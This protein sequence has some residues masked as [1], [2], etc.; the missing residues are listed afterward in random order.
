MNFKLDTP[1]L[2]AF[3]ELDKLTEA[4][5][6]INR[7]A[8]NPWYSGAFRGLNDISTKQ[9]PKSAEEIAQEEEERRKQEKE[10]HI[11]NAMLYKKPDVYNARYQQTI[12][13]DPE[14]PALD[15]ETK[16]RI[17]DPVRKEEVVKQSV[18]RRELAQQQA[19]QK[20]LETK[21]A[22][23]LKKEQTYYWQAT[24]T[25]NNRT[26]KIGKN[27]VGNDDPD[28]ACE[29]IK[30]AALRRIKEEKHECTVFNEPF[31]W[32]NTL[33]ISCTPPKGS[34]KVVAEISVSEEELD[35]IKRKI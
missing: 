7:V 4:N 22:N 18:E 12:L 10:Q 14:W 5:K 34:S 25:L 35:K 19:Y 23:K 11:R 24:Y 32:D 13:T 33:T 8:N 3:E 17:Y 15:P 2:E 20:G 6:V 1:L 16:E 26:Y 28:T 30:L 29:L 31:Q 21:A 9:T 27:I